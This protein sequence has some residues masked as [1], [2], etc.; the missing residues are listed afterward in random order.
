VQKITTA[1]EGGVHAT[2]VGQ[3]QRWGKFRRFGDLGIAA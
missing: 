2:F 3:S 1:I